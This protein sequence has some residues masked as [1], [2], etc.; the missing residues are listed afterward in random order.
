VTV[1][2][3]GTTMAFGTFLSTIMGNAGVRVSGPHRRR[4]GCRAVLAL[5]ATILWAIDGGC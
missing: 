1:A 2:I 5:A 4:D 3:L